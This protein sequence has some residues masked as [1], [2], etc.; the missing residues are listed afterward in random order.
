MLTPYVVATKRIEGFNSDEF[1]EEFK[2]VK[3][4]GFS[5]LPGSILAVGD[6][7]T[8]ALEEGGSPHSVIDLVP[9]DNV[10]P[11]ILSQSVWMTTESRFTWGRRTRRRLKPFSQR[12]QRGSR[13]M[14][15]LFP[16]IYLH[17]VTEA[18]R[19]LEGY[20]DTHW[21][22]TMR[23]ALERHG[24]E[25]DLQELKS[26]ALKH[27]QKLMEMPM[28]MLLKAFGSGEEE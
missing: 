27:A 8:I 17:A 15:V 10:E 16:A 2:T 24:I 3:P 21:A 11:R 26:R 9:D 20:P 4:G 23:K 25:D 7:M 5:I 28:G 13:E 19:N 1:A 14:A 22:S 6:S 18:L 12:G